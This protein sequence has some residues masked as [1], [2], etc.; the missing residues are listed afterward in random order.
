MRT[1]YTSVFFAI[2]LVGVLQLGG[3]AEIGTGRDELG[4]HEEVTMFRKP[5]AGPA[6]NTTETSSRAAGVEFRVELPRKVTAGQPVKLSIR[7]HNANTFSVTRDAV[8]GILEFY[9]LIFD[10]A[11]GHPA[12][13]A[14][15]KEN[16]TGFGR[17]SDFDGGRFGRE[18]AAGAAETFDI[19][20][21]KY[22]NLQ[23]G[24]HYVSAS[25]TISGGKLTTPGAL[26][27]TRA[28]FEVAPR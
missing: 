21:N 5:P 13:S 1:H 19:D 7:V 3:A 8:D 16:H 6:D 14:F 25:L 11:G 15:A 12:L 2:C 26:R 20:L 24:W 22:L 17:I 27:I 9:L 4:V 23:P 28:A 10:S 18:L